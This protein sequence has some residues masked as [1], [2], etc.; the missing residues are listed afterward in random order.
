MLAAIVAL[1]AIVPLNVEAKFGDAIDMFR[2]KM[3]NHFKL[4][5]QEKKNEKT[6]YHFAVNTDNKI[7]RATAGFAGGLTISTENGKINGES[8]LVQLGMDDDIGKKLA[9]TLALNLAYEALNKPI[10]NEPKDKQA[11][12]N[13]YLK[14]VDEALAGQAGHISYPG[15][16]NQL[17]FS[18]TNTGNL[19]FVINGG[20]SAQAK[21]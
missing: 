2:Q 12:F 3:A 15:Y 16:A 19:L 14:A 17:I 21:K 13:A 10:P 18:K 20:P 7:Q 4:V 1:T 9:A 6:Y 8:L 5:S 11:E